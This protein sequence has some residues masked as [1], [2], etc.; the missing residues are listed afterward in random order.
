MLKDKIEKKINQT[1][2]KKKRHELTR[3]N[4]SN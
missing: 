4:L 1:K 2:D 3:V